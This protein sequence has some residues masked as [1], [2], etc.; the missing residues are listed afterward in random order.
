[1]STYFTMQGRIQYE[2]QESF[3][4]AA[5]WLVAQEYVSKDGCPLDECGN[6]LTEYPTVHPTTRVIEIVF[7]YYRN[8]GRYIETLFIGGKGEVVWTSTDGMFEGGVV[9]DG[10]ETNYDLAEWAKKHFFDGRKGLPSVED[11]E[12]ATVLSEIEEAFHQHYA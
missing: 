8:L 11:K 10:E 2:D 5:E 12:Y 9:V 7:S 4:R 1:M 3:D 6:R